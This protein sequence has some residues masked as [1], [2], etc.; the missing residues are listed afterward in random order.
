MILDD[1]DILGADHRGWSPVVR[2]VVFR[3]LPAPAAP[4][5]VRRAVRTAAGTWVCGDHRDTPSVQ[6]ALVSGRRTAET[7]LRSAT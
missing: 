2:H 6:G 1:T 3:A 5:S 7:I 4:L